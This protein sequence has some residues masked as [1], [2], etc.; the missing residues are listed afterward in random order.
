[1]A[2]AMIPGDVVKFKT[3]ANVSD[4]LRG[5]EFLVIKAGEIYVRIEGIDSVGR[6]CEIDARKAALEVIGN[7]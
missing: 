1:M 7:L 6:F 4:D 5:C 3:T 2:N